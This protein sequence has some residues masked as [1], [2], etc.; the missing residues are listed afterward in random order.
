MVNQIRAF[1]PASQVALYRIEDFSD[2]INQK[3]LCVV[4]EASPHK[5]NL[6]LSRR[7]VLEREKEESR[8]ALLEQIEEGQ[9]REGIVRNIRDFGAFVD[10]GG[11][12]GLIHVSQLSWD[13]V[14]HPSEVLEEG[15]RVKVRVEKI[16]RQTGKIGLSLRS[17]QEHPWEKVPQQF[18]VGAVSKGTVTRIAKFGAFVKLAPGVEGLIHISELSHGRVA[19]VGSVV[20]EGQEVEVKVLSVDVENQRIGLSLKAL[21]TATAAEPEQETEE[22]PQPAPPATTKPRGP[23]KGGLDRS[24]GGESFGLQ[25]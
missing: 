16:D 3:L 10:L 6:V 11:V 9:S 7:A 12:D 23:L 25:W 15:Q 19:Q 2:Y 8:R 20:R 21:A 1:I 24:A 22:T 5:R 18:F 14:N 17:L 13:R 4:T